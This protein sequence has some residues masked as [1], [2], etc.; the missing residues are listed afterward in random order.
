MKDKNKKQDIYIKHSQEQQQ[1][2]SHQG[3]GHKNQ[4]QKSQNITRN[5]IWAKPTKE[6]KQKMRREDREDRKDRE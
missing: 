4:E 2:A 6:Q 3:E 1:K 5:E